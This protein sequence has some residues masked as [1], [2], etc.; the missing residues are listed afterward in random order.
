[1]FHPPRQIVQETRHIRGEKWPVDE[2]LVLFKPVNFFRKKG[3]RVDAWIDRIRQFRIVCFCAKMQTIYPSTREGG[4]VLTERRWV[5]IADW[6]RV[7][8]RKWET[9]DEVSGYGRLIRSF[10]CYRDYGRTRSSIYSFR[11]IGFVYLIHL[12]IRK[13]RN[14]GIANKFL[15]ANTL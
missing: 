14:I 4:N 7:F 13:K 10:N 2:L 8:R 1:M 3:E 6:F 12:F 11:P 9:P 15:V 5:R